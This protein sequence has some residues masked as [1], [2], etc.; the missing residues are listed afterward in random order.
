MWLQC[1][2]EYPLVTYQESLGKWWRLENLSINFNTYIHE[3]LI[4]RVEVVLAERLAADLRPSNSLTINGHSERDLSVKDP[5]L[6]IFYYIVP[7]FYLVYTPVIS[8]C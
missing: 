2:L 7:I 6:F 1:S 8:R 5:Y 4:R 3:S